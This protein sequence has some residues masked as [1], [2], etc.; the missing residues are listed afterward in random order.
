VGQPVSSTY[1]LTL[2]SKDWTQSSYLNEIIDATTNNYAYAYMYSFGADPVSTAKSGASYNH[3]NFMGNEQLQ[4]QFG[5][6]PST[7]F[8]V[9]VLL[10]CSS[11]FGVCSHFCQKN[12]FIN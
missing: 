2:L 9:D 7:N 6:A 8:Q 5:T 3:W 11:C 4:I 1:A 12:I 10:F